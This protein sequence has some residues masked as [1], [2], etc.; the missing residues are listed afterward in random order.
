MPIFTRV[1]QWWFDLMSN[2]CIGWIRARWRVTNQ[3]NVCKALDQKIAPN[4]KHVHVW[5]VLTEL[6][7]G[8]AFYAVLAAASPR[9]ATALL[10]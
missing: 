6:G 5:T 1:K 8:A 2:G 10:A 7:D 9:A 3:V 4:G